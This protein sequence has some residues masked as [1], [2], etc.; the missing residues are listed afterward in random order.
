MPRHF[1]LKSISAGLAFAAVIPTVTAHSWVEQVRR[2]ASNGT[3]TGEPGFPRGMVDRSDPTFNDNLFVHLL[4]PNSRA[5]GPVINVDDNIS[6]H[7][8]GTYTDKFPMLQ[9][10][11]ATWS[12]FVDLRIPEDIASGSTLTLYWV[13]D[14]PT[15]KPEFVDASANGIYETQ[16]ESV[17]TP[18]LYTSVVDISVVGSNEPAS[19]NA[20]AIGENQGAQSSGGFIADQ[21]VTNRAI[22]DQLNN[23]FL[24]DVDFSNSPTP[25]T[26]T[27]TADP[28]TVTVTSEPEPV[29][30]TVIVTAEPSV[31]EPVTVT[32]TV[33]IE[34]T[35][36]FTTLTTT[37]G[38]A[39][40][41]LPPGTA[42]PRAPR[43]HRDNW[44][45]GY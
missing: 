22:G 33:D 1:S 7:P 42:L 44:G 36:I 26:V 28:V 9:A 2:I 14:W 38:A 31:E 12:L 25:R 32:V 37:R 34:P 5:E 19:L 13:W 6:R 18:E 8:V 17:S 29:T 35:T 21:D 15:L 20:A 39:Q 27:V 41:T 16:G 23:M 40:A 10:S 30:V 24:V 11:P 3:F 43:L 45:F 4:P